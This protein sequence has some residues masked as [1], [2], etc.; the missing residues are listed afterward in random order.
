M[1]PPA[2]NNSEQLL[3]SALSVH[4]YEQLIKQIEKDFTLANE[5]IEFPNPCEVLDLQNI[6]S[7]K[8]FQLINHRFD[9]YLNLLYLMDVSEAEVK[10]LSGHDLSLMTNE[11]VFLI[12]KREW[13]KVWFRNYYK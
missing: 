11:V 6:L 12:L 10:K 3:E 8:L 2:V 7:D 9:S 13:Q 4:L 5:I 1:M